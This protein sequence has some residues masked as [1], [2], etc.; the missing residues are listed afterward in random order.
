M[1]LFSA[2]FSVFDGYSWL[3]LPSLSA[4]FTSKTIQYVHLHSWLRKEISETRSNDLVY[5][6]TYC[7]SPWFVRWAIDTH[8][9]TH[10]LSSLTPRM[11]SWRRR[12]HRPQSDLVFKPMISLCLTF[13]QYTLALFT[14]QHAVWQC[15]W[16]SL[17]GPSEASKQS[18]RFS[19][20]SVPEMNSSN[21][22]TMSTWP[23]ERSP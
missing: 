9:A 2:C 8:S 10:F 19:L 23:W 20:H 15:Y 4:C 1:T 17:K 12:L 11:E 13:L 3:N 22:G 21:I 7:D 5:F 6:K 18:E 14:T 16:T